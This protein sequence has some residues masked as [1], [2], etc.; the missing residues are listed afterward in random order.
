MRRVGEAAR[1]APAHS[2]APAPTDDAPLDDHADALA[3]MWRRC[4]DAFARV[5]AAGSP[6]RRARLFGRGRAHDD[7]RDEALRSLRDVVRGIALHHRLDVEHLRERLAEVERRSLLVEDVV[8]R[9]ELRERPTDGAVADLAHVA[10]WFDSTDLV[11]WVGA[12]AD[13]LHDAIAAAGPIVV[14]RDD[15]AGVDGIIGA[16]V[17][18]ERPVTAVTVSGLGGHIGGEAFLVVTVDGLS[19]VTNVVAEVGTMGFEASGLTWL[20]DERC[21][22]PGVLVVTFRR[23]APR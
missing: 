2:D 3:V 11:L 1:G 16:V 8:Q 21:G 10:A 13:P 5:E 4:D 7:A 15:A 18:T 20:S 19:D 23:R 14:Y 22:V 6:P 12:T 9:L 17:I